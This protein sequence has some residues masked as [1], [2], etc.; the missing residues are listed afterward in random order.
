MTTTEKRTKFSRGDYP[1][2][3]IL[4]EHCIAKCCR[5]YSVEIEAPVTATDRDVVRW[6]MLHQHASIFIDDGT[7]YLKVNSDCRYLLPDNRCGIY[8]TR[9]EICRNYSQVDCEFDDDWL[10]EHYFESVEQLD[11]YW[12]VTVPPRGAASIRSPRP[13]VLPIIG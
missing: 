11:E 10:Y 13:P 6:Y 12:E 1:E 4:C 7:W 2:G 3:T 8:E 5:Y 9:P